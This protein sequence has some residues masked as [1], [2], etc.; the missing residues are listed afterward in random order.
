MLTSRDEAA[1]AA[2]GALDRIQNEAPEVALAGAALLF[3]ALCK[4]CR[5]APHDAA[6]LGEKM[7]APQFGHLKG[8]LHLETIRDF[9]GM[10]MMGDASV[11]NLGSQ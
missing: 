6:E 5:T 8:N 7:L 10:R 1:R 2:F 9:A 3:V 4:R 11:D